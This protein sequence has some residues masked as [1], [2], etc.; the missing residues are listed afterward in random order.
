MVRQA[1]HEQK[2]S[3]HPELVEGSLSKEACRR[4]FL[5]AADRSWFD[6]LTTNGDRLTANGDRFTTNR[7]YPFILSLSKEACRRM[8]LVAA[9]RSWFDRLT[10]NGDR[11]TTNGDRLTTNSNRFTT[12]G[13]SIRVGTKKRAWLEWGGGHRITL[14]LDGSVVSVGA[15]YSATWGVSGRSR[16]AL[17]RPVCQSSTN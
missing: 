7:N 17:E 2:S 10:T 4:V 6:G 9:D 11:L 1:H 13:D 15:S 5:V 12:N 14:R 3:V 16:R 8:F